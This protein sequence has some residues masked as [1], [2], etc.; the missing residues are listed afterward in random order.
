MIFKT[1][2]LKKIKVDKFRWRNLN[3]LISKKI[4]IA[5]N[6][7]KLDISLSQELNWHKQLKKWVISIK[8][9]LQYKAIYAEYFKMYL[10]IISITDLKIESVIIKYRIECEDKKM[11]QIFSFNSSF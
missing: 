4:K 11:F 3:S 10:P 5:T 2:N 7:K 6:G 8:K 9:K 1:K